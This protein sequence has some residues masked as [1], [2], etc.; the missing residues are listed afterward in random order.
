MKSEFRALSAM[1]RLAGVRYREVVAGIA[2][3]S[4]TL[5]SALTLTIVSGWLITKAWQMPPVLDLSVAVTAVRGLGISRA[6]FRYVDRLLSHR[7]ALRALTTLRSRVFDALAFDHTGTGRGHLFTR[8]DGLVRLVADT[9][10]ITDVI[11]RSVV[12]GGVALVLTV[13]AVAGATWLHPAAG[14]VLTLGF[15]VTGLITPWLAVRA[16][17]RSRRVF[18]EDNLDVALDELLDHRVEF[19]AAGLGAKREEWALTASRRSSDATV[20]AE[21]PLATSQVLITWS[22]GLAAALTVVVGALTYTGDPTWLGMMVL[23]PLAAF[24]SHAQLS[25]AAIH[26]DEASRSAHRLTDLVKESDTTSATDGGEATAWELDGC[27]LKATDLRCRFGDT[28]WQVDLPPGE[29]MVIRGPSGCGKTTLLQTLGGLVPPRSGSVTLGGQRVPEIDPAAL[30]KTVRVH[31]EDE[32][33]FSTTIRQNLLVAN[34]AASDGELW[35]V[36]HAVGLDD[37]LRETVGPVTDPLDLLLADGAGSLSSGQRR[38]LLLA[39]A[40][41]STAPVLLLDEPTEHI[42]AADADDL[43]DTLLAKPLPGP[44]TRRS[45]IVVTHRSDKQDGGNTE[46]GEVDIR[47]YADPV[48]EHP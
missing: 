41:C 7:I 32:W 25:E 45:V 33:L 2:A 47:R 48:T 1:L 13:F 39:R 8:G 4:I 31:A 26:A 30:R 40:L 42:D 14:L 16:A 15:M 17:R 18:A 35:E 36:L 20:A 3:G 37:W 10:R 24:E 27:H 9:E 11:V 38:R 29:R 44:R 46:V 43:L 21:K 12:P 34:P 22:T 6:V 28:T 19:A 5:I 23:L